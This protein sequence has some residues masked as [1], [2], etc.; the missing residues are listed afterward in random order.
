[1]AV[2]FGGKK[3]F[4]HI[5]MSENF[6]T[7]KKVFNTVVSFVS[8]NKFKKLLWVIVWFWSANLIISYLNLPLPTH[9]GIDWDYHFSLVNYSIDFLVW[10]AVLYFFH[11]F[12]KP[13][14][15]INKL[16]LLPILFVLTLVLTTLTLFFDSPFDKSWSSGGMI[17]LKKY[18][19]PNHGA[20]TRI[21]TLRGLP[22]DYYHHWIGYGGTGEILWDF[23]V[24]EVDN[25]IFDIF[26]WLLVSLVILRIFYRK[27]VLIDKNLPPNPSEAQSGA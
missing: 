15:R 18:E 23:K 2:S 24:F 22:Y 16:K 17:W 27:S 8:F 10:T 13:V 26:F 9:V 5:F 4:N 7:F 12:W 21:D 11:R 20:Q 3:I 6:P 25:L 19:I 1:M 14:F